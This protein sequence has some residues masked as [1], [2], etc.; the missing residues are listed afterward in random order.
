MIHLSAGGFNAQGGSGGLFPICFKISAMGDSAIIDCSVLTTPQLLSL[1]RAVSS[2]VSK[3]LS[4]SEVDSSSDAFSVIDPTPDSAQSSAASGTGLL[5]P[6][7]CP[8]ACRWC[9]ERCT[10]NEGHKHHSCYEHR[11]R[12]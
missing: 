3:R 11:H 8:F 12:R 10:R 2:E 6:F 7:R 1:F 9:D 4:L 5:Q